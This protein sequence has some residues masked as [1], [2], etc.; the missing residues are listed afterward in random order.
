M[1]SDVQ[2]DVEQASSARLIQQ[3][4]DL[5][6]Q[7]GGGRVVLPAMELTLDRGL[8]LRSHVE[9]VGQGEQTL[10]RKGLGRIYPLA[11]YHNYGMSDVPLA[12]AT[13]LEVGMTVSVHD[14]SAHG[15]FYETFATITGLRRTIAPTTSRV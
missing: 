6:A 5:V 13:G 15:G 10:M 9:L 3:Q 11:G 7:A 14:G 8:A 2:L 4:I 12:D 1:S